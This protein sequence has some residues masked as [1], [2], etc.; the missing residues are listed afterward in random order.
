[1]AFWSAL[2]LVAVVLV[3]NLIWHMGDQ[4]LGDWDEGRHAV[5]SYEMWRS[6]DLLVNTY[7]GLVDYWNLKPP[8]SFWPVML[9]FQMFG[10]STFALRLPA[11]IETL[12]TG[13]VLVTFAYRRFGR[14]GAITVAGVYATCYP[15]I[16]SHSGRTA[17]PDALF[18]FFFTVSALSVLL[19]PERPRFLLLW[20]TAF[21]AAFLTKSWHAGLV[22]IAGS[23]FLAIRGRTSAARPRDY[24][25]ALLG[26]VPVLAWAIARFGFDGTRFFTNM[27]AYDLLSRSSTALEGNGGGPIYYILRLTYFVPW[28]ALLIIPVLGGV[29]ARRNPRIREALRSW[30]TAD[31]VGPLVI[32]VVIFGLFTLAK[33]KLAWYIYP[34]LPMIALL[35]G[36][37]AV[38]LTRR[39]TRRVAAL[40][41]AAI[42]IG[43]LGSEA[44]VV[45][46]IPG[47]TVDPQVAL[48]RLSALHDIAGDPIYLDGS[49]A[50]DATDQ[51]ERQLAKIGDWPQ[52]LRASAL[53]HSGIEAEDGGAAAFIADSGHVRFI[54]VRTGSTSDGRLAALPTTVVSR[55]GDYRVLELEG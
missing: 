14:R 52:S 23:L 33:S 24:A 3:L 28:L 10:P 20:T 13:V 5:S 49:L 53:I 7:R 51:A 37:A 21:S 54:L 50:L 55:A 27:V 11:V 29:A 30:R 12:A 15:L 35:I 39:T 18:V 38:A 47:A 25:I 22:I 31:W 48:A 34:A 44:Y 1:M 46:K 9:S 2:G 6:G 40:F 4:N 45:D 41:V 26:F 32:A 8:L 16:G 36:I 17:D 19:A 43:S 42:A